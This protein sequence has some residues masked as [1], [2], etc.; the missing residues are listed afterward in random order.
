MRSGRWRDASLDGVAVDAAGVLADGTRVDGPAA[1]R[2]A[3]T[4]KP[5]AFVRTVTEKLLTY[6][7]GRTLEPADQPAVR[8]IVREAAD[9]GYR[10]SSIIGG[11][12]ESL[13]FQMRRTES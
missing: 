8:R 2:G 6:A 12:V 3:L 4:A 9:D 11:V 7:I 10:W 5:E 13:P 1:L